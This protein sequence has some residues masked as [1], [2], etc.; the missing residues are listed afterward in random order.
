MNATEKSRTASSKMRKESQSKSKNVLII[1]DTKLGC[2]P[3]QP[4]AAYL[5]GSHRQS[6][7]LMR[8]MGASEQLRDSSGLP[9]GGLK[10]LAGPFSLQQLLPSLLQSTLTLFHRVI[11]KIGC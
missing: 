8:K 5:S 6:L 11:T 9:N 3:L 4:Q 2:V 1:W 10:L 7:G